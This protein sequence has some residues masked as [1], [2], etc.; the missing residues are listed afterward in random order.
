MSHFANADELDR[1]FDLKQIEQFKH[2]YSIIKKYP[3]S[4]SIHYRHI[5]NSAGTTKYNDPFFSAHRAGLAFYGYSPLLTTDPAY[6]LLFPLQ[7]ALTVSTTIVA[8]QEL[9]PHEL[10]S[11]GGKRTANE[12]CITATIPF[13]YY[14]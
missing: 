11:Y 13:G 7:P 5:N 10:V 6:S 8:L 2:L 4:S 1:T 9:A 12:Q 3:C 14:E